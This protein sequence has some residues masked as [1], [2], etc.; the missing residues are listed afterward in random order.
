LEQIGGNVLQFIGIGFLSELTLITQV[1]VRIEKYCVTADTVLYT[2][3]KAF[4]SGKIV[5]EII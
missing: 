1:T 4:L 5:R 2:T 3:V